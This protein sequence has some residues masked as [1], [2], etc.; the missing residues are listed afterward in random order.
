MSFFKKN[1]ILV[2]HDGVF[3]SDD[4]FATATLSILNKGN[5]KVFRTRDT[6]IIK[7]ADYVYDVGGEY[8]SARN[9]F[10]HHQQGGAGK[11]ENNVP[12]ASAGLVWKAF[13]EELCGSK[14]LADK[15]DKR[16]IQSI[17]SIDNGIDLYEVKGDV[18]PYT[19][20]DIV[21]VF[22]PSWKE[23]QN[24]D[25]CFAELVPIAVKILNREITKMRDELEAESYVVKAYEEASDKRLIFLESN[26]P[27]GET[28]LSYPEPLYVISSK[29]G[30][31]RVEAVRKGKYG[32]E[33]RKP[34]PEAWAGKRDQELVKTTGVPDAVFC[35]N[36]RFLV[37]AKTK[38][39][40]IALAQKA[41]DI[42]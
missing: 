19:L 38:E 3:H 15:I 11:R 23:E 26:Y 18:P 27:W 32:F 7:K 30:L 35:H 36:G 16:L 24:Y 37:V 20:Q 12:Y 17:D 5:I 4:L 29:N 14:I 9:L 10:D 31:W 41:L 1:K 34:F 8:D 39:A 21:F 6:E 42:N 25:K 13:G 28:L 2:T 40:V 33:N 22:R